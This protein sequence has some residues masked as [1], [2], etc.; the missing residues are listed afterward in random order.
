MT[1]RVVGVYSKSMKNLRLA[2]LLLALL[3][4]SAQASDWLYPRCDD[5]N[6]A[7]TALPCDMPHS[8]TVL[9][10]YDVEDAVFGIIGESYLAVGDLTGDNWPEVVFGTVGGWLFVLDGVTHDSLWTREIGGYVKWGSP[11]LVELT[12]DGLLDVVVGASSSKLCAFRGH[13]G[14]ALWTAMDT[15]DV[16]GMTV[17]DLENDGVPEVVASDW[18]SPRYLR[19]FANFVRRFLGGDTERHCGQRF[20]FF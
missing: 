7:S 2:S 10:S 5:R 6:T 20:P 13:D 11:V 14:Y 4:V 3:S 1:G 19:C 12:G 9:W 15:T 8:P 18:D 17:A 16:V